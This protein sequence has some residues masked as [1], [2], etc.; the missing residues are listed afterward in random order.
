M[1]NPRCGQLSYRCIG[2]FAL[3]DSFLAL[4]LRLPIALAFTAINSCDRDIP[5]TAHST[6]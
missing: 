6:Y 3:V 1:H 2:L 5:L 4:A